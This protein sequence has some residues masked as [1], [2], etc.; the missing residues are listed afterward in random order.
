MERRRAPARR[1][2][3]RAR[4]RRRHAQRVGELVDVDFDGDARAAALDLSVVDGRF[5]PAVLEA[6]A[7]RAVA[8]WAEA[9]DGDDAAL[10]RDRPRRRRRTR[11]STA[12]TRA[13]EHAARRPRPAPAGAADRR[14][15]AG[16]ADVHR[17]GRGQ[18]PPLRRGPRHRRGARG[19]QGPRDHVHRALDDRARR[20]LRR[21]PGGSSRPRGL[22]LLAVPNVSEGRD[23]EALDAHRRR[24]RRG[25]ARLLDVHTRP[26]PPPQRV[27]ARRRA[28][29]AARARCS[30][31]AR[32][33]VE[34][35]DLTAH[36]G[37]APAR[38]RARRRADRLPRRRR[39]RRRLRRGAAARPTGSG[40]DLGLP[41]FL[42][43]ELAG[44]RTRA[45]LRR[46]PRLAERIAP[47]TS[48][49]T[50]ARARCTRPP[51]RRSSPPARRSSRSTSRS[52]RSLDEARARSPPRSA[53]AAPRGCPA[54]ARS[55][56]SCGPGPRAGL[57]QHRGP[58]ARDRRG[59][60]GGGAPARTGRRG[61]ARRARAARRARG[62]SLPTSRCADRRTLED[63]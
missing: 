48:R 60:G 13:A 44:G 31:G 39:P 17:R 2:G 37:D 36:E 11:C 55:A 25:D 33:A 20:R 42:Y 52:T 38:R 7:R 21:R 22:P 51:A 47:A 57:H 30:E 14:A 1:G 50:T 58:H 40:R 49:P 18:R 63:H 61:R 3:D 35:I 41:V 15:R 46:G 19:L 54:C 6:A 12:A 43:G 59:R 45:E 29:H 23:R 27:H 5:A 4:G 24:V 56:S 28:R 16:A 26:R 8:A 53:R 10:E 32:E 62:T 34:R 9:V